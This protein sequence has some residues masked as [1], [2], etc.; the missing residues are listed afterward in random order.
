[1]NTKIKYYLRGL[2]TGIV[3]TTLVLTIYFNFESKSKS[4]ANVA[5]QTT[6]KITTE[7]ELT[8]KETTSKETTSKETTSKKTTKKETTGK[9]TTTEETTKKE[10]DSAGRTV[11]LYIQ[12]GMSSNEV[13]AMLRDLGVVEDDYDFNMY[14]YNNGYESLIR[15]GTFKVKAG[16]S[17]DELA[18]IITG[19]N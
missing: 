2:G 14:L 16:M 10:S 18:R 11:E 17:Y 15:V 19:R 7:K 6:S 1:M 3:V 4:K 9:E 12:S 13:A 5:N 8:E